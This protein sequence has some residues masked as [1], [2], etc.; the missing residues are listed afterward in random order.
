MVNFISTPKVRRR[1]GLLII[2]SCVMCILSRL[3]DPS[4]FLNWECLDLE[5]L[6]D[7]SLSTDVKPSIGSANGSCSG[8]SPNAFNQPSRS[9]FGGYQGGTNN[10]H[11]RFF[12]QQQAKLRQTQQLQQQKLL[13]LQQTILQA[14]LLKTKLSL[15]SMTSS[16]SE[17]CPLNPSFMCC[18]H[19]VWL[20]P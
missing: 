13:E 18:A 3:A 5:L 1:D 19:L 17:S 10:E 8:P 7:P 15:A 11:M 4:E 20:L 2:C 12:E 16:N 6:N 14:Q 9:S